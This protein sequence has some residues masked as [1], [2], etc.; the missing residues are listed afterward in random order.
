MTVLSDRQDARSVQLNDS[1]VDDSGDDATVYDVAGVR[2][3][4]TGLGL[5]PARPGTTSG[6]QRGSESEMAVVVPRRGPVVHFSEV[7]ILV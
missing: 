5:I 2:S 6:R 4:E 7:P 3:F 1:D